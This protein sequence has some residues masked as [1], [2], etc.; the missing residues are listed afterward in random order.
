MNATPP[1]KPKAESYR[2]SF[3][4][5]IPEHREGPDWLQK[6]RKQAW[7]R[8]QTLGFP[9]RKI[10]DW[11]YISLESLL[12]QPLVPAAASKFSDLKPQE[13]LKDVLIP[14]GEKNRFVFLNGFEAKALSS[15]A[16]LPEG[17]KL[18]NLSAAWNRHPAVKAWLGSGMES[19]QNPFAL[20]NTFRFDQGVFLHVPANVTVK[21]PIHLVVAGAGIPVSP[22]VFYPRIL[23]VLEEGAQAEVVFHEIGIG[24]DAYFMNAVAEVVLGKNAR[25]DW[26][27]VARES[28]KAVRFL[29][30]RSRLA[31]GSSLETASFNEN[32]GLVR[33]EIQVA[34]EGENATY[35]FRGLS[36][37]EGESQFFH[38]T[39]VDHKVPHCTSRQVGK[40]IL[41]GNA[42]AEFD[43]LVHVFR[44][45]QK[46]DSN[47][48]NRNLLLSGMART[49]SRPRL[50]IDADDV[51]CTHGSATGQLEDEEL[52]YLQSRG[53]AK[54]QAR[55]VLL[56]GFAQEILNEIRPRSLVKPF[57]TLTGRKLK[58]MIKSA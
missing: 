25:L 45:A 53:F 51:Q 2:D 41:A 8:F 21:S 29:A 19:E 15:D 48:L 7:E 27:T 20:I 32:G 36:L 3:R 47:Q 28:E 40:N 13:I 9:T 39:V 17:V 42:R 57:E 49:Y 18:E 55:F 22:P 10:E 38:H 31:G 14:D 35:G 1:M 46:S 34:M 50:R 33:E 37:L 52:F 26:L 16:D 23:V 4:A 11:K 12:N 6:L 56:D 24:K 54:E 44:N 58:E 43:N 5:G 30:L